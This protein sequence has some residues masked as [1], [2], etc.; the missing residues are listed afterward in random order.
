MGCPGRAARPERTTR[1]TSDHMWVSFRPSPKRLFGV[2]QEV[3]KRIAAR[4]VTVR[5]RFRCATAPRR[6]S[7]EVMAPHRRDVRPRRQRRSRCR[8]VPPRPEVP[9]RRRQGRTF[10][11]VFGC[12]VRWRQHDVALRA[13]RD[14]QRRPHLRRRSRPLTLGP[15]APPLRG[16]RAPCNSTS[17]AVVRFS[18]FTIPGGSPPQ[19]IVGTNLLST[20]TFDPTRYLHPSGR[21]FIAVF[22]K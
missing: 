9:H 13:R 16:W 5:P 20:I 21:D 4:V 11:P 7:F 15:R 3:C 17:T 1:A 6:S 22:A 10:S 12:S 2:D 19:A 18:T 14:R 8:R